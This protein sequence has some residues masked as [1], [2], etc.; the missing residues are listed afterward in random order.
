M[1]ATVERSAVDLH[2]DVSVDSSPPVLEDVP[3]SLLT[4]VE[5][6]LPERLVEELDEPVPLDELAL[7]PPEES[8]PEVVVLAPL[9]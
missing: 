9:L 2:V 7:E 5:L 3:V 6:E 1:L 4:D 8:P